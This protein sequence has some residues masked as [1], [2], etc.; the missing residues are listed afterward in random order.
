[1]KTDIWE[2]YA[3]TGIS[4]GLCAWKFQT[5]TSQIYGPLLVLKWVYIFNLATG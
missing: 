4:F 5:L 3:S 2:N 1:M